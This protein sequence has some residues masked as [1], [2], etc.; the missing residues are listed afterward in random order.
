MGKKR[1]AD[2]PPKVKI[3]VS[4]KDKKVKKEAHVDSDA[5]DDD[6][7][8]TKHAEGILEPEQMPSND[9][10]YKLIDRIESQLPKD[11][12]VKYDSR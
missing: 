6:V 2:E 3:K 10:L 12:V 1:K 9:I 8:P 4:K 11:D 5:S 7:E